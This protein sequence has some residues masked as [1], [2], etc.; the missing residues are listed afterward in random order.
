MRTVNGK[1]AGLISKPFRLYRS[2]Y[3][4]VNADI[5]IVGKDQ[6][7]T[8]DF[9]EPVGSAANYPDRPHRHRQGQRHEGLQRPPQRDQQGRPCHLRPGPLRHLRGGRHR[10]RRQLVQATGAH[11]HAGLRAAP[12]LLHV[13]PAERQLRVPR[14]PELDLQ[15]PAV[16]HDRT[17]LAEHRRELRGDLV[18]RLQQQL[19]RQGDRT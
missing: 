11:V 6:T 19:Q 2:G 12:D 3:E 16:E 7:I 18:E 1:S 10:H 15:D 8:V 5:R 13:H 17:G 4:P 9:T 14:D